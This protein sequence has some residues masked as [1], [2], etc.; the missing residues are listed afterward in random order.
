VTSPVR[1]PR[2]VGIKEDGVTLRIRGKSDMASAGPG[3]GSNFWAVVPAGGSDLSSI[4]QV[5]A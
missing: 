1:T 3:D 4:T 5:F 2:A